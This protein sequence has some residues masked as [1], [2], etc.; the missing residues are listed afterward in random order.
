MIT[1]RE[2]AKLAGVSHSTV[3]RSL[4]DSSE[5]S[6]ETKNKIKKIAE[7][8]GYEF[9]NFARG[10]STNITGTIGIIF[11]KG[12]D[13]ENA[14]FF[15][16][17][18]LKEL[19]YSLEK[20]SLDAILD[21]RLN[22]FTGKNNLKKLVNRKKIDGF[23]IVEESIEEEDIQFLLEKKVPTVFVHTKP[24]FS[25]KYDLDYVITDH[26]I[27]GYLATKYLLD[28]NHKKII[29]FTHEVK[30][31]ETSEFLERTKGFMHALEERG[32][33]I[34]NDMIITD[35]ISFEYGKKA[36]KDLVKERKISG[37]FAQTDLLALGIISGLKEEGYRVPED[38]SVVGYD[39]IGFGKFSEPNLST[40][41]QPIERLAEEAIKLL[42]D[43]LKSNKKNT[44]KNIVIEPE[45]I[46]RKSVMKI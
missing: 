12:F 25:D 13:E 24:P 9:N 8:K 35:E 30:V 43:K 23:I 46:I 2:I 1:I 38:I 7:E 33:E 42:I 4:N 3:S 10:L 44:K 37:I 27:G 11:N 16:V 45:L 6:E 34:K 31:E 36:I 14:S 22:P 32:I 5:I 20:E 39:N 18:L 26:F 15:F 29:T 21:F 17:K 40:I 28:N 41:N 19:R